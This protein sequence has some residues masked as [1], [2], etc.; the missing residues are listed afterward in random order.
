MRLECHAESYCTAFY[1]FEESATPR[2]IFDNAEKGR[3]PQFIW[4]FCE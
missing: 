1:T 3:F 2:M 4:V